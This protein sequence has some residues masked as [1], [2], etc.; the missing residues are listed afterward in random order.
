MKQGR[1]N[2]YE[3]IAES[4]Y[5][6][7][8]ASTENK[9]FI[10]KETPEWADLPQNIKTAWECA[11]R[12]VIDIWDANLFEDWGIL[13]SEQKWKGWVPPRLRSL[14]SNTNALNKGES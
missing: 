1:T 13:P 9:N 11:T 14:K 10:G 2:S 5:K 8:S 3:V 7:Y 4:A 6:A 12:Q